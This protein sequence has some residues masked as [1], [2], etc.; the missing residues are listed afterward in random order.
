L[1][2]LGN[3]RK[4]EKR[5]KKGTIQKKEK[6]KIINTPSVNLRGKERKKIKKKRNGG[7]KVTSEKKVGLSTYR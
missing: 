4:D 7:L 3:H 2:D 6:D 5:K 1:R